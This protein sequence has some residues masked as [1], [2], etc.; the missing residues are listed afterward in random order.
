MSLLKV[1][2]LCNGNLQTYLAY[3]RQNQSIKLSEEDVKVLFPKCFYMTKQALIKCVLL[4]I[5]NILFS[6]SRICFS[7]W[8]YFTGQILE[9]AVK[10]YSTFSQGGFKDPFD[11]FG[12]SDLHIK[13]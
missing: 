12:D 7:N 4:P 10:I 8:H 1:N 13:I 6:P 9:N 3:F 11:F 5:A 2:Y